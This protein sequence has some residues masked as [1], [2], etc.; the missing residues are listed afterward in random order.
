MVKLF[1]FALTPRIGG[2]EGLYYRKNE[3]SVLLNSYFNTIPVRKIRQY[4]SITNIQFSEQADIYTELGFLKSGSAVNLQEVPE[5]AEL[6]YLQMKDVPAQLF[7]EADGVYRDVFPAIIICTYHRC[8]QVISNID[9]ILEHFNDI[10]YGIILVDNASEIPTDRWDD[11]RVTVLHN[12]NNGGSGG[13]SIGMQYASKQGKYTH[14]LLMDDDVTVD[15]VALQ[16]LFSFLSFIKD[17]YADICVSGSMLYAD[18]PTIQ[19]ECGG[20]FEENGLQTGY[21]YQY[22]LIDF[23][24][25]LDNEHDHPINYGGWWMFCMPIR[26]AAEGKLPAPFFIKYDDVEYALRCK[27]KIITLN[28]VGVWHENFGSKY[29]SVQEYFN[30]RNYLF[31]M[32]RCNHHFDDRLAKKK[33]RHLLLEKLCRQQYQMAEAVLKAYEDFLK[34]EPYLDQVNYDTKLSELGK[35][36][37]EM[38]PMEEIT[39]RYGICFDYE[40]YL[41]SFNKRFQRYMQPLLYG[42]LIPKIFCKKFT[43]TDVLADR[44]EN[45]FRAKKALHYDIYKQRGYITFKSLLIFLK[46]FIRLQR[47]RGEKDRI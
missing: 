32:K 38:L 14:I 16:K 11:N 6:L 46:L 44:K 20:Y 25:L 21:G 27:L 8:E 45:Y 24:K 26:Y 28:G 35:L 34:G 13:F 29:N 41:S 19:F 5:Q 1:D 39:Q 31:L 23:Q 9:Y 2:T 12:Q 3:N 42:H 40:L 7:T 47:T 4:T 17:E 33:V 22:D 18:D 10:P 15:S 37:Y 43:I 30:T 36:D